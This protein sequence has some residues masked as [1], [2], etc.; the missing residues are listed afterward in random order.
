MSVDNGQRSRPRLEPLPPFPA[1]RPGGVP[2]TP[3]P[4]P[5]PSTPL[6]LPTPTPE[7]PGPLLNLLITTVRLPVALSGIALILSLG[8]ATE[9]LLGF[10]F[11]VYFALSGTRPEVR[12]QLE[13]W[14]FGCWV[15]VHKTWTWALRD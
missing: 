2:S 10:A 14:P 4:V 9:L 1:P 12:R 15:E 5:S 13:N 11:L 7:Q 6:P 3:P 8:W